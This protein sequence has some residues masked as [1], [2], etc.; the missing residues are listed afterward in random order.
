M[1]RI[2][3]QKVT[4]LRF[5]QREE[6]KTCHPSL[7]MS[8]GL[9]YKGSRSVCISSPLMHILSDI[10]HRCLYSLDTAESG[11]DVK[12]L[13]QHFKDGVIPMWCYNGAVISYI[14]AV[15]VTDRG[16]M[17]EFGRLLYRVMAQREWRERLEEAY[18]VRRMDRRT[19]RHHMFST[20]WLHLWL[21]TH[22]ETRVMVPVWKTEEE[23]QSPS[24]DI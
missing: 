24:T 2:S 8:M 19:D 15:E 10:K 22:P 6:V 17:W 13:F 5:L 21:V 23:M 4:L 20:I 16:W 12:L 1:S 3:Y 11:R 9:S 18:R 14:C 7:F